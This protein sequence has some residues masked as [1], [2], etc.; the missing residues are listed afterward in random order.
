MRLSTSVN[1][2]GELEQ[3]TRHAPSTPFLLSHHLDMFRLYSLRLDMPNHTFAGY[4]K[5]S[6]AV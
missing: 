2:N 4:A 3:K 6:P 1:G 5:F